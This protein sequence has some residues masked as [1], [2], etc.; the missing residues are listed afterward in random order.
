MDVFILREKMSAHHVGHLDRIN[1]VEE[2]LKDLLLR[3]EV[4]KS[5]KKARDSRIARTQE[6]DM[7]QRRALGLMEDGVTSA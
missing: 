1:A 3:V 4:L 7:M 6:I 5:E 2:S